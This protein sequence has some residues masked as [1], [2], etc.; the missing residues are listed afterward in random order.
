[1]KEENFN[2]VTRSMCV[3]LEKHNS[4]WF[5]W[6]MSTQMCHVCCN[7][8]ASFCIHY[9]FAFIYD[10]IK[11]IIN[12]YNYPNDQLYLH[13]LNGMFCLTPA[14][15]S[16]IC[17]IG[18]GGGDIL[19]SNLFRKTSTKNDWKSL[20]NQRKILVLFLCKYYMEPPL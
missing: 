3:T 2:W 7:K 10:T 1:M 20:F 19:S 8:S 17:F 18:A 9:N 6:K 16:I 11:E 14:T 15:L 5:D 13:V 4:P 12:Q